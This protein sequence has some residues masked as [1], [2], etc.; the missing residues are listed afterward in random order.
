MKYATPRA[1]L[2]RDARSDEIAAALN[3]RIVPGLP[4]ARLAHAKLV[5]KGKD[6]VT[7][8]DCAEML[9]YRNLAEF[10]GRVDFSNFLKD[11]AAPVGSAISAGDANTGGSFIPTEI[12]EGFIASLEHQVAVR[13]FI[14]EQNRI[15]SKFPSVSIPSIKAGVE[16]EMVSETP[17]AGNQQ[18]LTTG[19]IN[20]QAHKMRAECLVSRELLRA[21]VNVDQMIYAELAAAAARKE[22]LLSVQGT[23]ANNEF[24][25]LKTL[26]GAALKS[27]SGTVD[28]KNVRGDI[29]ALVR[30]LRNSKVPE[31]SGCVFIGA[32][33]HRGALEELESPLGAYP[34]ADSLESG[35]LMGRPAAFSTALATDAF[36]CFAPGE[37]LFFEQLNMGLEVDTVY[38]DNSGNWYSAS[39]ADCHVFRLWRGIDFALKHN[40][41]CEYLSNV[42]WGA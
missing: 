38:L 29:R 31:S 24:R 25:G 2:N 28:H 42:T 8:Q 15:V 6:G 36:Y 22:D 4:L 13:R 37:A 23:G 7:I 18:A 5:M 33:Q 1:L 9:G 41:A 26:A 19:Q 27:A 39:A 3:P 21:A 14:P 20:L 40:E 34:F 10:L 12:Q 35:S 11:A 32:E 16:A 17:T 30:A